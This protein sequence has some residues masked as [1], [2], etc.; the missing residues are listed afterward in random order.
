MLTLCET[1]QEDISNKGIFFVDTDSETSPAMSM[2]IKE[3]CAVFMNET[4][5]STSAEKA[6]VLAHELGHCETGAFYNPYTPLETKGRCEAK[7]N[8][9][10]VRALV[11]LD[12]L[13][14]AMDACKT[15]DGVS[16]CDV[17]EYLQITESFLKTAIETYLQ[18]GYAIA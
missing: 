16:L 9:Y 14:R 11:P 1:L 15:I 3:Y 13:S 17:A 4:V 12:E 7:A 6:V 2:R 18:I 10:A 8:R 5:F